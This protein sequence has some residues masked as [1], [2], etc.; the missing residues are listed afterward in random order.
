MEMK[1]ILTSLAV[2]AGL[3]LAAVVAA[4][5]GIVLILKLTGNPLDSETKRVAVVPKN[6]QNNN[7]LF[8][9]GRFWRVNEI[10]VWEGTWTRRGDSN[11]FDAYWKHTNG[12]EER[13]VITFKYT[14]DDGQIVLSRPGTGEYRGKLSA[15]GKKIV[16]GTATWY[17]PGWVWTDRKQDLR[18]A[19][20]AAPALPVLLRRSCRQ[21]KQRTKN[22]TLSKSVSVQR[23]FR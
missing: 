22:C 19:L 20:R 5:V 10:G 23:G 18:P 15:D 11:V 1:K 6:S 9:L 2:P 14:L 12:S 3:L 8:S 13:D 16:D 21:T 4:M 7:H 17:R